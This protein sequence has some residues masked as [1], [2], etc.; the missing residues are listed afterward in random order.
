ME[1]SPLP[2][3]HPAKAHSQKGD[4]R[5]DERQCE[6]PVQHGSVL[7][8][9]RRHQGGGRKPFLQLFLTRTATADLE[10]VGFEPGDVVRQLPR[11]AFKTGTIFE[12]QEAAA[13]LLVNKLGPFPGGNDGKPLA[14]FTVL[15]NEHTLKPTLVFTQRF[16]VSHTFARRQ[17]LEAPRCQHLK[18]RRLALL[19]EYPLD[20]LH[21]PGRH[22]E[23]HG[24]H[25]QHHRN[26][27]KKCFHQQLLVAHTT[28]KQHRHFTFQVHAPV[29]QQDANEKAQGQDQLQETGKTVSHNL[30]QHIARQLTGSG[31]RQI[32][33]KPAAHEHQQQNAGYG[34]HADDHL[35]G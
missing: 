16:R 10:P 2:G 22:I 28:G 4:N 29:R 9:I 35:A 3:I 18:L 8:I 27:A 6:P 19:V 23:A 1:E 7:R 33:D 11:Q 30:E 25:H 24:P 31:F 13:G 14:V 34:K 21:A 12:H 20:F 5:H 15:G 32:L 26:T 17:R